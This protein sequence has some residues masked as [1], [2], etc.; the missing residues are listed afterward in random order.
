MKLL[1]ALALSC[2]PVAALA[3]TV[4]ADTPGELASGVQYVQPKD[5]NASRQERACRR[6]TAQTVPLVR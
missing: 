4:A 2:A 5:W 3:Q 1:L 6:V